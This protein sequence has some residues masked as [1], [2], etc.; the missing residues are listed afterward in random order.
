MK[1]DSEL[2]GRLM[3]AERVL[4][5]LDSDQAG[6]KAAWGHWQDI[7][8]SRRWPTVQGKDVTEQWRAGITCSDVD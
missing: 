4:C 6:A 8:G 7:Q 1:P 2:H 5:C 3:E